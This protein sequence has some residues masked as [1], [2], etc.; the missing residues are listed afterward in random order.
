MNPLE[1]WG[2]VECSTVR[3]GDE[4]RDQCRETGHF[5]RLED[6]DAIAALG[7]RTLRYPI[8]WDTVEQADGS[9]DFS[10]H[11]SRLARLRELGIRIIGGLVHHGSG[12]RHTDVLDDNWAD[13]LGAYAARVAERYP[14]I[15]TWVPV[16]EPLTTSRF[17]CLYGHWYP[18]RRSLGEMARSLVIQCEGVAAAMRAIRAI[19]PAA[20]LMVTEDL[21]KTFATRPL[22]HQARHE[23]RRRWLTLDLLTG[24]LKRGH[25]LFE[26]FEKAGIAE[27]RLRAFAG[28]ET[29][30]D[31][32]GVDHYLTSERYLD[33]RV[34]RYPQVEPGGNGKQV[35]VDLEAVR[36]P[37]LAAMVGPARR[38][39]EIWRRYGIPLV[40][41]EVHHGCSRDEQLRWFD[42][43]WRETSQVRAEGV[44][45]RAVTLWALFG[46]IDWRS[47]LTR[48][49]GQYDAGAFDIR[50]PVPRPTLIARAA[51]AYAGAGAFDHP[52]LD[53]AGWW[54]RPPRTYAALRNGRPKDSS[55]GRPILIAG[56][57]GTLGRAFARICRHRGLAHVLT[58]RSGLDIANPA[59]IAAAID[60][61]KPWAVVNA[62]GFVRVIEAENRREE[63]F[64][65]N[66]DGPG[67]LAGACRARGLPLVTFSSD[68]VFDGSLGRA[69]VELD[70]AAPLTAYGQSK[71]EGEKRVLAS[72][73][74][75]LVIRSSAFFGPW[76][77]Y[78]FLY[79]TLRRLAQ[80]EEAEASATRIVSPTYVPE[81][82]QAT[83][84]LLLDEASGL[85]HVV[86]EGAVSF[87]DL[88]REAADRAGLD[89]RLIR[90]AAT[91]P[92]DTSLSSE[93]GLLLRPVDKALATFLAEAETLAFA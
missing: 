69:Y 10:W 86:N 49:E 43:V 66:A 54:R 89:R 19:N 14:W 67:H 60:A 38:L 63:C 8:L 28:G 44:D 53:S 39:R 20:L 85:W 88:A 25:P 5:D 92:A 71:A 31:L 46:T 58:D 56:A 57:T 78:N 87:Y 3:I 52:A 15:D 80:G 12:P 68:L 77:R 16:N 22:W 75:A 9:L 40:F 23:N 42:Q 7:I 79:E 32:I 48:R 70:S 45:V 11:D 4:L 65:A 21:G 36:I 47:L 91:E 62:A 93:R 17:A 35:Y 26:I 24:R 61:H 74:D 82:V 51:S 83:L 84:D 72:H 41:G 30:P 18:H 59:S 2:G 33:D 27:E 29:V 90:L 50:S 81:L 73:N 37:R 55:R 64:R 13:K 34:E 6:L 1:L 76:D